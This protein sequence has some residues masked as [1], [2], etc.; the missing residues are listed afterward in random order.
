MDENSV[1]SQ[2]F[3]ILS[4]FITPLVQKGKFN[5]CIQAMSEQYSDISCVFFGGGGEACEEAKIWSTKRKFIRYFARFN[6]SRPS[7]TYILKYYPIL[8]GDKKIRLA[9][10]NS[11]KL[12]EK[13]TSDFCSLW[14]ASGDPFLVDTL[15][16]LSYH[17][18]TC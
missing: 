15:H 12:G 9:S 11:V 5:F 10:K 17:F 8:H 14:R 3:L 1:S 18:Q 13:S 16:I 4:S 2:M 6:L 7:L